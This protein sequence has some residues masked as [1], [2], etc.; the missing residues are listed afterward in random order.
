MKKLLLTAPI[1]ILLAPQ[2]VSAHCPLCT[3]GAGAVAV[4]AAYYGVNNASIGVFLGAFALAIGWWFARIIDARIKKQFIPYQ[5]S[6]IIIASFLLTIIPI[7]PMFESYSS[8][9]ISW[10]GEYGS[11]LNRTYMINTFLA[12]SI[13]G[14][15]IVAITPLLSTIITRSRNKTLPFQGV[16]LTLSL[17]ILAGVML[18][19]VIV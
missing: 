17:I 6:I 8:I 15:V 3:I 16:I 9:Y 1:A 13:L 2:T 12:G 7:M 18:Q 19:L 14:G 5:K 10:A 4:G 11:L